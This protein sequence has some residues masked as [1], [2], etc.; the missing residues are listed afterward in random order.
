MTWDVRYLDDKKIVYI[1]S[2]GSSTYQ[3][4]VEQTRKAL[5]LCKEHNTHL[6]LG[7]YS[8]EKSKA[9]I[10]EVFY[11]PALYDKLGADKR[12][13]FAVIVPAS[14]DEKGIYQFYE[15]ICI[16]RGRIVKLF[17]DKNDALEWLTA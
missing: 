10:F 5:Q 17:R 8:T 14:E 2:K 15:T 7:D 11:L 13:K 3:D 12:N 1:A 4:Y 16:N 6:L 9:A